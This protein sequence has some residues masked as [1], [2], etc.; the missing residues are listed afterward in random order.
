MGFCKLMGYWINEHPD[1][2]KTQKMCDEVIEK[3]LW[4]LFDVPDHFKTKGMCNKQ[5]KIQGDGNYYYYYDYKFIKWYEGYKKRKAQKVKI[6][7][8][9]LPTA[10]HPNR[11]MD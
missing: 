2:F 9:L 5:V 11:A 7:E 1:C 4:L 8:E 10:W 3:V 6:K